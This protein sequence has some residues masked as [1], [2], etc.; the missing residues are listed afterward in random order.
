M[1]GTQNR[2]DSPRPR[3]ISRRHF[4]KVAAAGL[5]AGCRPIQPP[6]APPTAPPTPTDTPVP[7]P[8][9]VADVRRPD[10]IKTYPDGPSK[11]VHAHHAGV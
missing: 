8:T 1:P 6:T 9:P 11:V 2:S 7:A 4:L 10:I 3:R 5:L